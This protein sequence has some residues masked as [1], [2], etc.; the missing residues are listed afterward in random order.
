MQSDRQLKWENKTDYAQNAD[1]VIV[2]DNVELPVNAGS[3]LRLADAF[4]VREVIFCGN[5]P[6]IPGRKVN[7][8]ARNV[9]KA[10]NIKTNAICVEQ[11]H[12]LQSKGYELVA[13]EITQ[14]SH[15]LRTSTFRKNS[16]CALIVGGE[17][18]GISNEVLELCARAV[19]IPMKGQNLSMNLSSALA[20][21]LYEVSCQM[22]GC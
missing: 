13:V 3:I 18:R 7:K 8:V 20:I 5:H 4:G 12:D 1:I 19:H 22:E 9:I 11:L 14:K 10:L 21:A 6:A 17:I 16:K 2:C 15:N